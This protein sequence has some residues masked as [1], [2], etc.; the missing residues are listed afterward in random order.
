MDP[1]LDIQMFGGCS[2]AGGAGGRNYIHGAIIGMIPFQ[3]ATG[4]PRRSLWIFAPKNDGS[5]I[6]K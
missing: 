2:G 3:H 6:P 1:V 5:F 4:V